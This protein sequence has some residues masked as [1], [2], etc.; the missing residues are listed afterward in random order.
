MR[1]KVYVIGVGPGT[2]DYLLP[3]AKRKIEEADCLIGAKRLIR[4]FRYLGKKEFPIEGH[5][6]QAIPYIKKYKLKQKICVLVSG[7][8]GIYSFLE[9]VSAQLH[10]NDY[11]VIAGISALQIAFARIQESWHTAKIISLHGRR[12]NPVRDKTPQVTD[13]CLRQPVSNGVKNLAKQLKDCPKAF[14]FTD[15]NFP[16]N[17]IAR[18]LLKEGLKNRKAVIL[19]NLSYPNERIIEGDLKRLTKTSGWGLCVMIIETKKERLRKGKLYGVGIGPGDPELV[20]LKAKKILEK[21]DTIFAPKGSQDSSSLA[22]E[23]VE[24]VVTKEKNFIELTFPMTADKAILNKYWKAAAYRIAKEINK[25]R[26]A[27][28]V[29]I[30]D[31]FIYSTY[32][33]LL[34]TLK[35]DFADIDVETVPGISAFNAAASKANFTLVEGSER[36]AVTA[37]TR[38]L[39]GLKEILTGF[40][41]VVLMK[42]GSKLDKV[43]SLLKE[44]GLAQNAVLISR[45]G[46]KEERII[47]N[48]T[49]LKD[50][51]IGYLSVILVKKERK[52]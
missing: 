50:K 41:T 17:K 4:L 49:S 43:I 36:L 31:P 39:K 27:A 40:D 5:F 6:N 45:V 1:N 15:A 2:Q 13:G 33:Y 51:K 34:K 25:G 42:V 7:D 12:V 22:R 16:P 47:H 3:I 23:I 48:L 8:P 30:G 10:K 19:E 29:T 26:E 11:A 32:V 35:Q 9:K 28:F 37:V 52:V 18:Y 20:T 21:V 14:L 44:L 24:A 38:D 46:H